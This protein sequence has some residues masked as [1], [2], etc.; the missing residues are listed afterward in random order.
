MKV[1]CRSIG[2]FD[3]NEELEINCAVTSASAFQEQF[4]K[5]LLDF[6]GSVP[7]V[8]SRGLRASED[9]TLIF[10]DTHKL[11]DRKVWS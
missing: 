11:A 5:D 10:K 4:S 1:N 3:N 7:L 9:G 8:E 6:I 2:S